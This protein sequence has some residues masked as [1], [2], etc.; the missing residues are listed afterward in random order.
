MRLEHAVDDLE[1]HLGP[2]WD[3]RALATLWR[4]ALTEMANLPSA[5]HSQTFLKRIEEERAR[6]ARIAMMQP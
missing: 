3:A 6:L 1:E 5:G 2:V 4:R